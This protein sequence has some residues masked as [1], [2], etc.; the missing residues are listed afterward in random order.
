[1]IMVKSHYVCKGDKLKIFTEPLIFPY[2]PV[3][4]PNFMINFDYWVNIACNK[5]DMKDY[6]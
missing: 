4:V 6:T 3:S 2:P 5:L 1:M